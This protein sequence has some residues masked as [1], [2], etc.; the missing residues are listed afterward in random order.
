M[1]NPFKLFTKPDRLIEAKPTKPTPR[2][3]LAELAPD[4]P[5]EVVS[6]RL[7]RTPR[8]VLR[9]P[10]TEDRDEFVR[11]LFASRD[12]LRGKVPIFAEPT[13]HPAEPGRLEVR[14]L[15]RMPAHAARL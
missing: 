5:V 13:E 9:P 8:L 1:A 7:I 4:Q 11:V 15:R 14:L 12:H 3:R 6:H 10:T 2:D